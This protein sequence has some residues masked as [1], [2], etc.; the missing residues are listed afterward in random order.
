MQAALDAL[1]D[2]VYAASAA[3]IAWRLSVGAVEAF[4]SHTTSMVLELPIAYAI[5]ICA[6]FSAFLAL[7]AVL[8]ALQRLRSAA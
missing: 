2:F 6:A 5:G 4:T 3:F 8:T 1:W 7:I